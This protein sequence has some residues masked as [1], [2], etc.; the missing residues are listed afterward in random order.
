ML[1][2]NVEALQK[3]SITQERLIQ[4][5]QQKVSRLQR[6]LLQ[7]KLKQI[8]KNTERKKSPL[9]KSQ[10][11]RIDGHRVNWKTEDIV[12]ALS[13]RSI[14]LKAYETARQSW[15]IP[16][17]SLSTLRRWA[18]NFSCNEGI[19][20]DVISVMKNEA[21]SMKTWQR[22]CAVSFDEMSVASDVVYDKKL[23]K[24]VSHT[25]VQVAMVRGI[26]DKWKQ[27]LF[28]QFDKKMTKDLLFEIISSLEN[29]GY[30]VYS[31][32]SDLG[33]DNQALWKA[34]NINLENNSFPNPCK[35][36]RSVYVFA[37]VPHML[38]LVRNHLLDD[39]MILPDGVIID[40]QSFETLIQ[41]DNNELKLCP[42][43]SQKH[44]E[45]VGAER[46]RVRYAAQLLSGHTATLAEKII[47][48]KSISH[49]I[50]TINDGFDILNSRVPVDSRNK[51][52]SG[53]GFY[54]NVQEEILYSLME[55]MEK[56]RFLLKNGKPKSALLPCQKGFIVSIKSSVDLFKALSDNHSVSYLL[57]SRLNQDALES[58]FSRIRACGGANQ[59][60]SPPEFRYR[61]RLILLGSHITP[62]RGTNS[63]FE[64]E[65]NIMSAKLL[66]KNKLFLSSPA[67]STDA[68]V[69][70]TKSRIQNATG[71][72]QDCNDEDALHYL[73][74]YIAWKVKRNGGKIYGEP[75]TNSIKRH[76]MPWISWMT[77][78]G[79]LT[80]CD[81]LFEWVK[82]CNSCFI[83]M[84]HQ[85]FQE[86]FSKH[87]LEKVNEL[88]PIIPN[89]IIKCFLTVRIDIRKKH[90]NVICKRPRGRTVNSK[91]AKQFAQ[92]SKK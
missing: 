75:T 86:K 54:Q 14:G 51:L 55:I 20:Q 38:K 21:E 24:L 15:K 87:F 81:E 61:L 7:Q 17:P 57:T 48:N 65:V 66:Q 45:V 16:L 37:D 18:A 85:V 92:S 60:P 76:H 3:K 79:L 69:V 58:F 53:L 22:I 56:S 89:D 32:T 28:Y 73:A 39:G 36:D 71:V 72:S 91:K 90:L 43:L 47:P 34:L 40:K 63:D 31:M 5:L 84:D 67:V 82:A 8:P 88:H 68:A 59:H 46:M 77:R 64:E 1:E 4:C 13:V 41:F 49:C 42:R 80:P 78:G 74:G 6:N 25:K 26:C 30:L 52:K 11:K 29:A 83:Q 27:P 33:A 19:L 62:P 2:A 35:S 12:R 9:T 10:L 50:R 70:T 23:D 44:L